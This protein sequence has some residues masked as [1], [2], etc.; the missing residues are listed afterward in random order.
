MGKRLEDWLE[1]MD[2]YFD[3]AHSTN[4]NKAMMCHCKL[5]KSAKLWWQDHCRES[6][7][8]LATVTWEY[9][10]TQLI[11]NYQN[12]TYHIE[13]LNEFIDFS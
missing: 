11:K 9:I 10:R 13:C 5:E 7:L 2:E 8:D 4:E 6:A 3:H 1:K 12:H